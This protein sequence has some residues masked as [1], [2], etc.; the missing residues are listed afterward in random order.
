MNQA[1]VMKTNFITPTPVE[2]GIRGC[3]PRCG[4]GR[5][6]DGF[7]K[8][9]KGCLACELDYEFVDSGD[10][11]AVFIILIV[12]FL[13]TALAMAV[14]VNFGPPIWLQLLIWTP[15]VLA[16]C[17]WALRFAKGIMISL[18]YQTNARQGELSD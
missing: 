5:L 15:V 16:A 2:V 18:Q 4:Q 10:G 11:P 12:G 8:P 6:Y 3:C 17:L 13:V 1:S 14:Q 9:A 7:L